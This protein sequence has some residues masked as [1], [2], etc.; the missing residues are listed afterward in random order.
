MQKI[1]RGQFI[2]L[3]LGFIAPVLSTRAATPKAKGELELH[4]ALMDIAALVRAGP[5]YPDFE[6]LAVNLILQL[7]RY[8]RAGGKD[9]ALVS[10]ANE[11]VEAKKNWEWFHSLKNQPAYITRQVDEKYESETT[12]LEASRALSEGAY[13]ANS[14]A[15]DGKKDSEKLSGLKDGKAKFISTK[16]ALDSNWETAARYLAEYSAKDKSA[17]ERPPNRPLSK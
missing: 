3:G 16:A 12:L 10:A 13:L 17:K 14:I 1:R 9:K 5:K 15:L 11:Y 2:C 8:T 4:E 6:K 7:D